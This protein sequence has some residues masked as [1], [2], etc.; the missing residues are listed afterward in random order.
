MNLASSRRLRSAG[1]GAARHQIMWATT[2]DPC[3][4]HPATVH[5]RLSTREAKN[6]RTTG[7]RV[8]V[9]GLRT[10]VELEMGERVDSWPGSRDQF[11]TARSCTP[12]AGHDGRLLVVSAGGPDCTYLSSALDASV[13]P[14]RVV[15]ARLGEAFSFLASSLL[16][17]QDERVVHGGITR[18]AL[19][20]NHRLSR[21]ALGCF[22]C[23]V[24][25]RDLT[26]RAR[27]RYYPQFD[28]EA[29]ERSP[30]LHLLTIIVHSGA[31]RVSQTDIERVREAV[32]EPTEQLDKVTGLDNADAVA[33]LE[34]TWRTWDGYGTVQAVHGPD[35]AGYWLC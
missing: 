35:P 10:E 33:A 21:P 4:F 8:A 22:S 28:P 20:F 17:L 6:T 7:T 16:R 24:S 29:Q 31:P 2:M 13:T 14:P 5:T 9:A 27:A 19:L 18:D 25:M 34:S 26:G 15:L 12:L 30:E 32:G 3:F 11:F 23:S 1:G